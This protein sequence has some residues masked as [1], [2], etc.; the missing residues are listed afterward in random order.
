M[1]QTK[2]YVFG[3]IMIVISVIDNERIVFWIKFLPSSI[4]FS[5]I[6]N[7]ALLGNSADM[8]RSLIEIKGECTC[9]YTLPDFI[10]G[11]L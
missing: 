3:Y 1:Y 6:A 9:G 4:R 7:I 8:W 11:K 10:L 2:N 5:T